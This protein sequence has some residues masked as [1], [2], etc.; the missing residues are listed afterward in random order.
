MILLQDWRKQLQ[1][2]SVDGALASAARHALEL[3]GDQPVLD[4]LVAQLANGDFSALPPITLLP[5][6]SMPGAAGAYAIS[7]G[8]I[9]LNQ[10]WLE[11]ATDERVVAV[12]TEE[13]GHHLDAVLNPGDTS[14]DEGELI[15]SLLLKNDH[16]QAVSH[17]HDRI[18]IF[19]DG[20]WIAAEASSGSANWQQVGADIEGEA[21][22]DESGFS[23]SLSADGSTVAIGAPRNDDGGNAAG[24]VRIYERNGNAWEQVGADINGEATGDDFRGD[25]F[26]LNVSLSA[27]GSTVAAV[28]FRNISET[29]SYGVAGKAYARI[30]K[31]NGNAWEQVG[32]DLRFSRF[33]EDGVSFTLSA[34]GS[35]VAIGEPSAHGEE[36][37]ELH[38]GRVRIYKLNGNAW[39][40]VGNDIEGEAGEDGSGF[41]VSLSADGSTVAIGAPHNDDGGSAAGH[42]RIYERNGNTWEQVGSDIDGEAGLNPHSHDGYDPTE[43]GYS[44]SLSAD[45]S[46]V[47]IGAPLNDSNGQSAGQVRIY[48]R[49]GN[50]WEQVG[51]DIEGEAGGDESGHSVSLSADG[52]T[53]AI[54]APH[55]YA[56]GFNA[57][58]VRVY[59]QY[60]NSWVK[61]GT[62]LDGEAGFDQF[63]FSVSLSADGS[64]VAIGAPYNK[65]FNRE[66]GDGY[67]SG[68][69][70]VY[71]LNWP[72]PT[73]TP[74][75][76]P[77]PEPISQV[78]Y[79]EGTEFNDKL[80][81]KKAL[82]AGI[83]GFGGNDKIIGSNRDDTLSGGLGNDKI[84][85]KKGS[86]TFICLYGKDIIKD[87]NSGEGDT[88]EVSGD[89]TISAKKK[90][91]S[92][93]R[94]EEGTVLVK[95]A[96]PKN[97]I[98]NN[99][100][101]PDPTTTVPTDN[102]KY[103]EL[104]KQSPLPSKTSF[105]DTITDT[106][107]DDIIDVQRYYA[108]TFLFDVL[109]LSGGSDALVFNKNPTFEIKSE[110]NKNVEK[111]SSASYWLSGFDPLTGDKLLFDSNAFTKYDNILTSVNSFEEV[112]EAAQTSTSFIYHDELLYYNENGLSKGLS[113]NSSDKIDWWDAK[114]I[115]FDKN[116]KNLESLS[117]AIEII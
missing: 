17:E 15:S 91:H 71:T 54:G 57:G 50:T 7:T 23:V 79:L 66:G 10:D 83:Y 111:Q 75:P 106:N 77:T 28:S 63:G 32:S 43:F 18:Q 115:L 113:I 70:R 100:A 84:K 46:T 94:H 6:S 52:S 19:V 108:D 12:L 49:N 53:V 41:S 81:A 69:V 90:K 29:N 98:I 51:N 68:H 103:L 3:E 34:D 31:R 16:D 107:G 55:H 35:T 95:R 26:G 30:Y 92:L 14:G 112:Y 105:F 64:T 102:S 88:V 96:T 89:F 20:D 93:I 101:S 82:S 44:V 38:I 59:K 62:D 47:A 48:Q 2:W 25:D 5:A 42:V 109:S 13:M 65:A 114:F 99:S 4:N 33:Y 40:Q 58:H 61:L 87:Y 78:F 72:T 21:G 80:K 116:N 76:T 67:H 85:G 73:P 36:I 8:T 117:Q 1:K 11:T 45:G 104:A 56:N 60:G 9:Y 97:I 24:H 39:E 86:D 37:N 74:V 110:G 22:G 27:D